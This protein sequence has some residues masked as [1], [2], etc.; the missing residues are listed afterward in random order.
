MSKDKIIRCAIYTRKSTEDGLDQEFNSLQAQREAAEAYIKSQ[1][2]EGWQAIDTVYEDGGF[3]GGNMDRPGLA[4]LM[5]DI[6]AKKVDMIVVY[7]VDRLSRSLHDFAKMVEAFDRHGVSFVSVTQ[8]F[9]TSTS[10]GRL[11]L[12]VLL[13]FA[14]FERE[15][16]AER[17]RDKI[18]ASKRKGM[19]MGG[20]VPFGY[21]VIARKL[22]VNEPEAEQLRI[23]FHAYLKLGSVD[24]LM[25][26][27]ESKQITNKVTENGVAIARK[28][29]AR[30]T[31]YTLL[32]HP[33]YL[34]KISFR[35]E[36]HEGQHTAI[37]D[38]EIWQQ[39]QELLDSQIQNANGHYGKSRGLL[40][41]KLH[42]FTGKRYWS[43]AAERQKGKQR[44]YYYQKKTS[45][46]VSAQDI[47]PLV[48]AALH[49]P[50]VMDAMKLDE[51]Q[52]HQWKLHM[53]LDPQHITQHCI[54]RIVLGEQTTRVIL[55]SHSI[56]SV[57][58][59]M[60]P[61]PDSKVSAPTPYEAFPDF[62]VT[63]KEK[64]L[65]IELQYSFLKK[66]KSIVL[67][68]KHNETL[69]SAIGSAWRWE[70]ML[71]EN[72]TLDQ[73]QLAIQEKVDA[74]YLQ[75]ALNLMFLAPDILTSILDGTQPD[76]LT[77]D[78]FKTINLPICWKAQRKL[79]RI[80]S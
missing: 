58:A 16:T 57:M 54:T 45:H 13:S 65:E 3:S 6:E 36:V 15:V 68:N 74:R 51:E 72:P 46:R 32:R 19:W 44:R 40:L 23:I 47:E 18:A 1:L 5:A 60:K 61:S 55:N 37:L 31:L 9:N 53:T 4:M 34:G 29:F 78:S 66:V 73:K 70:Q 52:Q 25:D 20:R 12:N 63:A 69:L 35:D 10:M 2:H 71:R 62:T 59:D 30:N 49:L 38:P 8:Q 64:T 67:R 41:G 56:Q 75:R 39:A 26:Y 22:V 42:D 14:Q 21:D 79:L 28:P 76:H 27:L 80:R 48:M 33:V 50:D 17:I 7:K 11:T 24:E 77:M 43:T